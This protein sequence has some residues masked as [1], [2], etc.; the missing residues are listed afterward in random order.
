MAE[1]SERAERGGDDLFDE[2]FQKRLE[3]LA[4]VSRRIVSGRNRADR[5]SKRPGG[6]VGVADH[7]QDSARGEYP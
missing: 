3:Y 2:A 4:V 5:R 6:G 1:R 7:R